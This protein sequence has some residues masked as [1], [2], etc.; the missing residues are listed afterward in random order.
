MCASHN[1]VADGDTFVFR[2]VSRVDVRDEPPSESRYERERR[3]AE[4]AWEVHGDPEPLVR[5][6]ESEERDRRAMAL[7]ERRLAAQARKSRPAPRPAPVLSRS[8]ARRTRRIRRVRASARSPGS[9]S[10]DDEPDD[11]DAE[12]RSA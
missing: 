5:H 7:A 4:E 6:L 9:R 10:D 11:L 2:R 3:E 1:P 8:R 12:R